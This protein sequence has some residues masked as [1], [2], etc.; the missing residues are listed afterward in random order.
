MMTHGR[1]IEMPFHNGG[2]FFEDAVGTV[3]DLREVA[4]IFGLQ[5][6]SV[7][8]RCELKS[9]YALEL[10]TAFA[11]ACASMYVAQHR[12]IVKKWMEVRAG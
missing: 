9:G 5:A 11:G 1:G 7:Y 4:V 12:E 6:G 10:S 8:V 2:R 3:A